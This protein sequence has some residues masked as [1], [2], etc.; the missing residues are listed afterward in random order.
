MAGNQHPYAIKFTVEHNREVVIS[1]NGFFRD[2]RVAV[3]GLRLRRRLGAEEERRR[4]VVAATVAVAVAVAAAAAAV[5]FHVVICVNILSA[6]QTTTNHNKPLINC[7]CRIPITTIIIIQNTSMH[8]CIWYKNLP[9]LFLNKP[10]INMNIILSRYTMRP[11]AE[12]HFLPHR[13]VCTLAVNKPCINMNVIGDF[14][15]YMLPMSITWKRKNHYHDEFV[16]RR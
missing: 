2:R 7:I 3:V 5:C 13:A 6:R 1:F 11:R 10:Y 12:P 16:C 8:R 15:L 9:L 14:I 4:V